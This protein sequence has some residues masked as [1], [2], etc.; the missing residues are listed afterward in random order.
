[1]IEY[2][3]LGKL[4]ASFYEDFQKSFDSVLNNGW[5]VLG[6]N[7]TTFEQDF[8][9]YVGVDHGIGVANGLDAL[10][11]GLK[12]LNL[13]PDDEVIVPSNTYIATI[14]AILHA[15]LK[16][17]LVEP[18]SKTYNIDPSQIEQNISSKTRAIIVVHLYGKACDMDPI[19]SLCKQYDLRLLEDCAQSHGAKYKGKMTGSFGDLGC[20]SFYPTKNL[21]ALG[22]AG[23]IVCGDQ[24]L[25]NKVRQLRNYGS[26][27]K[28]HNDVIG[29]NSRLDEVQAGF[30]N[31]KLKALSDIT[32]H[33][34]ML[35][36]LYFEYLNDKFIKPN[37][38][39]DYFDVYH[40]FNIRHGDRD[41]L[42]AYMLENNIQTEI[43]YP[44]S[45]HRQVAM[46]NICS[47]DYPIADDIHR[48]T[49][50]LPISF[51]H[52]KEDILEVCRVM[53]K[54]MPSKDLR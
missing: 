17:I 7:V 47:G 38:D 8:S 1:M 51:F 11:L 15:G 25:A 10:I 29:Y 22:D 26:S 30:L 21:G 20:F 42:R 31:I 33:K 48:T 43:H 2:E 53:N 40:I 41:G 39:S 54:F 16:P 14:L 35:A 45:P 44:V 34:R 37:I 3:N 6:Q 27:K 5:Y 23:A 52:T 28:Y 46:K 49:L 13:Q 18:D 19:L 50:S 24:D 32:N 9:E 36:K 4:N 12:A